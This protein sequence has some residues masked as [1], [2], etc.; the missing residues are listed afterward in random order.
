[1][2]FLHLSCSAVMDSP[3]GEFNSNMSKHLGQ[4]LV[5]QA[6]RIKLL[7]KISEMDTSS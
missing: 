4:M 1:M 7:L 5:F 6:S 2:C 3:G